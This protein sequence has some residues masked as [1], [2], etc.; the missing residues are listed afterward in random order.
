M[1]QMEEK[2]R[3]KL[4]GLNGELEEKEIV[5]DRATSTI[6]S[7]KGI[8]VTLARDKTVVPS[9]A[10]IEN[11]EGTY[12]VSP[13]GGQV[14][15]NGKPAGKNTQIKHG[16]HLRFGETEFI[17]RD[18]YPLEERAEA[19]FK[20]ALGP[21]HALFPG[22]VK[23]KLFEAPFTDEHVLQGTTGEINLKTAA[24][25]AQQI[26]AK[27][28]EAG[29]EKHGKTIVAEAMQAAE[30]APDSWEA[31]DAVSH[32]YPVARQVEQILE[33]N[34]DAETA[35][36]QVKKLTGFFKQDIRN[37]TSLKLADFLEKLPLKATM[38]TTAGEEKRLL[39]LALPPITDADLRAAA[40]DGKKPTHEQYAKRVAV[41]ATTE[42]FSKALDA[43][44]FKWELDHPFTL[45]TSL[46]AAGRNWRVAISPESDEA[47]Q[48]LEK[49]S[50]ELAKRRL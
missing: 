41:N 31:V 48:L 29:L 37:S 14:F 17:V 26:I 16:D 4:V 32:L 12:R 10:V 24:Q 15:V 7:R 43:R 9:H 25:A 5:L 38:A 20:E 8:H 46:D 22:G 45:T 34:P 21:A 30:K 42:L 47:R 40:E 1:I 3:L 13:M 50:L 44:H 18:H 6:G 28:R 35:E 36:A 49:L 23:T 19:L 11:R 27:L 33:T 2:P 39:V